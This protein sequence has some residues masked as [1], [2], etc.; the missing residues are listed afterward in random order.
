MHILSTILYEEKRE[1]ISISVLA[2]ISNDQDLIIE[3]HDSGP[4]V[5]ELMGDWD[6]EYYLTIKSVD[7]QILLNRI[8]DTN[9]Q[10][11]DDK[12]LL[13]WLRENYSENNAFSAFRSFLE[14][15]KITYEMYTWR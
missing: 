1:D 12:E 13:Y 3:G 2:K 11:I 6:Y 10:V 4:R 8:R 15:Q 7:K 14:S 9:P 5:R